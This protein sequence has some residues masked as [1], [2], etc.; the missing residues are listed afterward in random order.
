MILA[1]QEN[2]NNE[3]KTIVVMLSGA[4]VS[5]NN[6]FKK[7][8]ISEMSLMFIEVYRLTLIMLNWVYLNPQLILCFH[9]LCSYH[10]NKKHY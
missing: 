2:K 5:R 3:I 1:E 10:N 8:L 4:G 6:F 9:N 7:G